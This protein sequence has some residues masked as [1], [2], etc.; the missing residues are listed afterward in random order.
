MIK[1]AMIG[2]GS[3]VFSKNLT[4]DILGSLSAALTLSACATD[5]VDPEEYD[6]TTGG[7]ANFTAYR[8]NADA[9]EAIVLSVRRDSLDITTTP[10]SFTL[11][12]PHISLHVDRFDAPASH[13]YCNDVML[14][15]LRVVDT[16]SGAGRT[17]RGKLVVHRLL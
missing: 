10:R 17:D 6:G 15:N 9:T 7:C 14:P 4:G 11:P 12:S 2:A 8:Y 13:Y 3:V 5:P 16:C 1:I